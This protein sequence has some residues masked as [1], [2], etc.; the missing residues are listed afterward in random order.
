MGALYAQCL[1]EFAAKG[2]D[3]SGVTQVVLALTTTQRPSEDA[4]LAVSYLVSRGYLEIRQ[5]RL[6]R[7]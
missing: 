7:R 2:L 4:S 6:Y 1:E 5:N 3:G